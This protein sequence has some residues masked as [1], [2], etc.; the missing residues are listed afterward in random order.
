MN[1]PLSGR[2]ALVTGGTRGLGKAIVRTL[3]ARG[4]AVAF[5]YVHSGAAAESL[6]QEMIPAA[7]SP[8]WP[9]RR[10]V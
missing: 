1:R 2:T 8:S 6:S 9:K 7:N 10:C 3:A 5:S 4:A